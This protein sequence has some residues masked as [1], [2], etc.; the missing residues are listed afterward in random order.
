MQTHC[1]EIGGDVF[2]LAELESCVIRGNMPKPY[3]PKPPFVQPHRSSRGHFA[4][5]L[6]FLDP[7]IIFV[8]NTGI[9]SHPQ[10]IPVLK[11]DLL[12]EQL[13]CM[14]GLFLNNHVKVDPSR[15]VVTLPKI[16][17]V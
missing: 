15:R 5:A 10:E 3:Y 17:D 12:E 8:L 1:Y 7:R 9:M 16:C 14:C 2:S 13:C 6:D 11:P 4:Y